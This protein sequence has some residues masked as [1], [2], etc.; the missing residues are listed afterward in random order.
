MKVGSRYAQC[1]EVDG[2]CLTAELCHPRPK[3]SK[4][5]LWSKHSKQREAE[6]AE[7][8]L[9]CFRLQFELYI[10]FGKESK[11]SSSICGSKCKFLMLCHL[12][13]WII[14]LF[15]VYFWPLFVFP[16][17]D[18]KSGSTLEIIGNWQMVIKSRWLSL[19]SPR[20]M[21]TLVTWMSNRR[22]AFTHTTWINK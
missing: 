11:I 4:G 21:L 8:L 1:K 16:M 22:F 9:N 13:F 2:N 17:L 19:W 6:A 15:L 3:Y 7:W 5:V 18:C 10:F 12:A 14:S 20:M